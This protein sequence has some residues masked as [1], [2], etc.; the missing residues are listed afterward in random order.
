MI[1]VSQEFLRNPDRYIRLGARPPRGVLLV[2]LNGRR[3]M[4][5]KVHLEELL[6]CII[7]FKINFQSTFF[8]KMKVIYRK[9]STTISWPGLKCKP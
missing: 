3:T 1:Y 6:V 2:S 9:L 5:I 7:Y 8:K 4:I